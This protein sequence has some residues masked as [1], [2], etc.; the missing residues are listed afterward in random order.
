M[1]YDIILLDADETL[2]DFPDA[3]HQ[4]LVRT[5]EDHHL[6]LTPSID[7]LY[8]QI[9]SGLW[10]QF[11]QQLITRKQLLSTRFAQLFDTLG[12]TGI[13]SENFNRE[14]LFNLGY[15]SKTMPYAQECC[16][17]LYQAGCRLYILTNGVAATQRRR[18]DASGLMPYFSGVFVSEE[19]GYQ[20][21]LKEYFDYVF[22]RIP[23]FD[24]QR[25]LMVGDSLSSDIEGARRAGVDACW[26]NLHDKQPPEGLPIRFTISSLRQLPDI[27]LHGAESFQVHKEEK[28]E[29]LPNAQFSNH[30][31]LVRIRLAVGTAHLPPAVSGCPC[32]K[33]GCLPHPDQN[34]P[35]GMVRRFAGQT[36]AGTCQ[37]RRTAAAHLFRSGR[38]VYPAGLLQPPV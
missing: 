5:F 25:A 17:Q 37:R 26:L 27:I 21:P 6:T 24:R 11:E 3:E 32:R 19:S 28:N 20:K 13:D 38:T 36:A 29:R 30:R 14:Y 22:A 18:L 34:S 31:L 8:Q 9:N 15:G 7:Q 2:M 12:I 16:Q 35:K 10:K 23:D 1:K 33:L 4:A